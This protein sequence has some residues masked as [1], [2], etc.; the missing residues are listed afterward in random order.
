M[1]ELLNLLDLISSIRGFFSEYGIKGCV[2]FVLAV[3]AAL[4]IVLFLA[5]LAK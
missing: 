2:L 5:S 1:W 3:A 4:V